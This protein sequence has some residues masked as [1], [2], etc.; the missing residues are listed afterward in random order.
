MNG[1]LM[2]NQIMQT[3]EPFFFPGGPTGC[4]LIHGF[5]GTPKEMLWMGEYL[6]K[7]GFTVLGIRL[8]G[9]ATDPED[10]RRAHWWDWI[11]SVEDGLS[12]LRGATRQVYTI[13]LSMGGILSLIA[14]SRYVLN[15]AVAISTPYQLPSDWRK[16]F[17]RPLSFLIR[18]IG[19]GQPDWQNPSAAKDH[20]EYPYYPTSAILQLQ[21]LLAQMRSGLSEI[22]I[23]VLLVHSKKDGNISPINMDL[24]HDHLGT[25]DK[26]KLLVEHSGHVIIREPDREQV[27]KAI[28]DFIR[29]VNK[30]K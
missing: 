19:K 6:S 20:V 28:I 18:K 22:R 12:I 16:R 11:A 5:T 27:F 9:H 15:G 14:A 4:L 24:I 30:L 7:R 13:G 10:M 29:R 26:H 25:S 23:P 21:A 8:A 3:A 1:G 2:N 17:I